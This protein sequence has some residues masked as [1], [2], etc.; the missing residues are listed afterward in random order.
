MFTTALAMIIIGCIV[1]AAVVHE[2]RNDKVNIVYELL[3]WMFI[4]L[5]MYFLLM[6]ALL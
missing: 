4:S 3:F 6:R 5:S 1:V 2:M